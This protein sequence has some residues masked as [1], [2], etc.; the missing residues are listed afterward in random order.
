M[1]I[2]G[3]DKQHWWGSLF[4]RMSCLVLLCSIAACNEEEPPEAYRQDFSE[5]RTDA[6]GF[7]QALKPDG[8]TWKPV[9]NSIGNLTPDS[10]YR[11]TAMYI[12]RPKG[13]ELYNLS[14]VLSPFPRPYA[15]EVM[16]TDPLSVNAVWSSGRYINLRLM[17]RTGGGT[18]YFGF[19]EEGIDTLPNGFRKLRLT[20]LHNQNGDATYYSREALLSCPIY[21]YVGTLRS[22]TDSVC[23]TLHTFEGRQERTFVFRH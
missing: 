8:D 21:D 14:P 13:V 6:D 22:G 15:P 20:L 16:K 3:L 4:I 19:N 18:H 5:L 10:L 23:I 9:L 1:A 12:Q 17:L 11:V 2:F 7:V